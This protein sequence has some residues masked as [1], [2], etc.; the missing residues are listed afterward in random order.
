[1][2]YNHVGVG[3]RRGRQVVRYVD[4]EIILGWQGEA[5]E[6]G[7]FNLTILFNAP[8]EAEDYRYFSSEPIHLDLGS[9]RNLRDDVRAYGIELGRLLFGPGARSYLDRA[10]RMANE[11]PVHLRLLLSD[12]TPPKYQ[13]VRWESLRHP[14]SGLRLATNENIRFSRYV[15][16]PDGTPPSPLGL[17]GQLSALVVVAN[18]AGLEGHHDGMS[19]L[20]PADVVAEVDRAKR[21]LEGMSVR[22]LGDVGV[23]ATRDNIVTALRKNPTN[24]LYLVCHGMF[25]TSGPVLFLENDRGNVDRVD[26]A[27]LADRIRDLKPNVPT[28]A[29]L[30]SCQSAG[31]G[32]DPRDAAEASAESA[33]SLTAFGPALSRAGCAVVVAMQGNISVNTAALFMPR[34]F[35]ELARDGVAAHAMAVARSEVSDEDDWYVP[36]LYSRLKRGSAWYRP[37]FGRKK[38]SRFANLHFRIGE[39][40]CTPMVGSGVAAEDGILPSRDKVARDWAERRQI[41]VRDRANP[42]LVSVAQYVAVDSEDRAA[43]QDELMQYLRSY[44]A[45]TYSTDLPGVDWRRGK[46]ND[47]IELVGRHQRA[48]SRGK[49]SYSRLARLDVPV[50]VT[51]AWSGLLEDALSEAGRKPVTG[52]FQWYEDVP[53]APPDEDFDIKHPLVYHLFGTLDKPRSLVLTEDDYFKWLRAWIKQVDKGPGIPHYVKPPLT[54]RSL[55]FL[56]Y[57]FEDWEFRMILQAIKGFGGHAKT[58]HVGV[59]LRPDALRI[60]PEAALEY[61]ERYLGEDQIDVYWESS[62]EF[63]RELEQAKPRHE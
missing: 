53:L 8:G 1:M 63:L 3:D 34:F 62:T 14:D 46:L 40:G 55:L 17:Q 27:D 47:H 19:Q 15:S 37:G 41:P 44:L 21:S 13:T 23:P 33:E 45:T 51:S 57:G 22:V 7:R 52:H 61:L 36:V 24:L 58:R 10:L 54:D 5:G 9:L 59:Q 18:P 16:N 35:K 56:G 31:P 49:D 29:V 60:E 38:E 2:W 12:R 50:F 42:D 26:G 28:L 43:A 11:I 30:V 6:E 39:E 48:A 32:I 20:T 4:L 25:G